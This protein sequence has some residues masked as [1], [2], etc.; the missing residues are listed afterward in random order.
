MIDM[1]GVVEVGLGVL[2]DCMGRIVVGGGEGVDTA[3]E[4]QLFITL[5]I[6]R[7][8]EDTKTAPSWKNLCGMPIYFCREY[9]N[10]CGMPIYF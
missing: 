3:L 10:L 6:R 4:R 7:N 8:D 9:A 5:R 2:W 1:F